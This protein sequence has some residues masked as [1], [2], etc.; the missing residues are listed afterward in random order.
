MKYEDILK[1]IEPD[2]GKAVA[3]LEGE[4]AKM[5]TNRATP[6]LVEDIP[7]ECF[8]QIFPLKQLAAIFAPEPRQLLVQPWDK[9]YIDGIMKALEKSAAGFSAS[10]D[11]D[12][13]RVSLPQL[14]EEYRKNLSRILSEKQEDTRKQIRYIRE[15][16][17]REIQEG[18][19]NGEIR[20]DDKF[21]GKDD[22]QE[23]I[24]KYNTKIDELGEKKR[25]ELM[26]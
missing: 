10:V 13:V 11:K 16:A 1:K 7:V 14:N 26:E 23:V 12:S 19:K 21:K 2:L 3:F 20:E 17:W 4:L 24:D 8:G 15:D 25:K 9:S 22:L 6:A 5:R 18:F